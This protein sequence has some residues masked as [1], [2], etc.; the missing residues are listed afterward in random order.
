MGKV[1]DQS[2]TPAR[3]VKGKAEVHTIRK[4]GNRASQKYNVE[5]TR[6]SGRAR[7]KVLKMYDF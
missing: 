4:K 1:D 5:D 7:R 3:A 2:K 6:Y